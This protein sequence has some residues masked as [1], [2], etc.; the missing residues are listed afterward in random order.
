MRIVYVNDALAIWG[1]LER[2]LIEKANELAERYGY[3]IFILTA[4]QGNHPIPFPLCPKVMHI[5][6]KIQFHKQYQYHGIR[7]LFKKIE[8][9][10]M[11]VQRLREQINEIRADV[12]V[13][14]RPELASAV[15]KVKG[16]I[17]FVFESHTSRYAQRFIKADWFTQAKNEFYNYS[18]RSAQRVVALTEGDAKDWQG[19]NSHI[20]VI[21]NMVH[22]NSSRRYCKYNSKSV[23]FVG[24]FS[25]QKDIISLLK[26]WKLVHHR[27]SEWQLQI[28]GGFGEEQERLLPIIKEMNANIRVH[29]PT[30]QIFNCYLENSVFLLTSRYEPFGLVIPE[31]MSCGLPV[32]A[33][34]CPYGPADIITNGVDGFLIKNRN[35]AEFA[36]KVCMLI[37]KPELRKSMGQAGLLSSQ[38]YDASYIMPKWKELFEQMMVK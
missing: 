35:I 10:R 26:I 38:R 8:L 18:V 24:R 5:D 9:N 20:Q 30:Q 11:F 16:D 19:I 2:I 25:P 22:L 21:P 27:H 13:C 36:E 15:S 31:A 29:E 3:D 7:R 4:N 32:V 34:D 6:L 12:I 17:P 14:L 37:E 23:M 28:Y 1:G 33:F